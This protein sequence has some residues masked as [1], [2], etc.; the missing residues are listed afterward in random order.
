MGM[1]ASAAKR[2]SNG[3]NF[4]RSAGVCCCSPSASAQLGGVRGKEETST[5]APAFAPDSNKKRWRKRRFWRKKMKARK[6]IGG[7]VDLVNDISAKSG[8]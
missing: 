6:E 2:Y 8:I 4:L 5:S 1:F 7:L 3:K